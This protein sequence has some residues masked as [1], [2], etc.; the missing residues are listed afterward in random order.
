VLTAALAIL[1]TQT[2]YSP[3]EAQALFAQAN[4]AYYAQNFDQAIAGYT[5]LL[6]KGGGGPDVLFNLGT[7][8][9]AKGD[10]GHAVLYLERARKLSRSDDIE[11]NLTAA[12]ARQ[13]D[14]VVGAGS[15]EP[16]IERLANSTDEAWF[17]WGL[18]GALWLALAMWLWARRP[19][20]GA[21]P[22]IGVL[23]A[24]LLAVL[25]GAGFG[26]HVY[27]AKTVRDGVVLTDTLKVKEAPAD[28]AKSGF[29]VHSGL[30]VRITD[31]SGK[32]AKVRLANG[33]D[34]WVEKEA[35]A[36]L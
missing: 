23:G 3:Q 7:A 29:E 28:N 20:S 17:G 2:W 9:L 13:I 32:F 8:Y 5:Q 30:K 31:E 12:R 15:G 6:D 18:V 19:G 33:L 34:G 35:V 25:A 14:Q 1:L 21:V 4:D 24:L 10:L 22:V 26:V 16:F 27:V 11:G 36:E